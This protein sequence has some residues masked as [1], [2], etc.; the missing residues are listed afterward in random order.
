MLKDIERLTWGWIASWS[1][2]LSPKDGDSGPWVPGRLSLAPKA[3][4]FHQAANV[5]ECHRGLI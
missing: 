3:L 1:T 5:L 2:L 4:A